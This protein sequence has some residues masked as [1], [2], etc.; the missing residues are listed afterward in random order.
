MSLL[1]CAKS[2]FIIFRSCIRLFFRGK[3]K[4]YVFENIQVFAYSILSAE[5]APMAQTTCPKKRN[6][7]ITV[8]RQGSRSKTSA[9]SS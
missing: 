7:N 5:P 6:K 8:K 1:K 9:T 4:R 3:K 2:N